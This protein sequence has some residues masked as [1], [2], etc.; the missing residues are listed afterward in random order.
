MFTSREADE[1]RR[2]LTG[3]AEP[4]RDDVVRAA[5]GTELLGVTGEALFALRED[6]TGWGAEL[7]AFQRFHQVWREHGFARMF[8]ELVAERGVSHRLLAHEDGERRLTN[9]LHLGELLQ[10]EAARHPRGLDALVQW[11]AARAADPRPQSEE[12]Q[13]RLESDEHVVK[14][15]TVHKSKGLQYPVVFCPFVWDGRLFAI[16]ARRERDVVCHDP[17]ADNRATLEMEADLQARLRAAGL[18]RGAGGE[19][20]ALLRRADARHPPLHHRVGGDQRCRH[21]GAVLAAARS[22]RGERLA[23]RSSAPCK[24]RPTRHCEPISRRCVRGAAARS[25]SRRRR[26]VPASR[27]VS[28]RIARARSRRD[29]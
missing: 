24:N 17:E 2:V 23:W 22:G 7:D 9:L 15:V 12:Q 5:L 28:P 1:L 13:L 26:K 27:I 19:P 4:G 11:M 29:P 16:D 3:V 21:V 25:A 20:A 14:I 10:D 18:S 6:D 8:R